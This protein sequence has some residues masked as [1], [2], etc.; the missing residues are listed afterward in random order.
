MANPQSGYNN[1]TV[2]PLVGGLDLQA[3]RFLATPGT[4][5]DCL[6]YESYSI[7]GYSVVDGIEPYDGTLPCYLRDWVYATRDSGSGNFIQIG[8]AHV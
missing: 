6:N 7:S 2:I 8:R 1:P 5:K 3:A 4:L